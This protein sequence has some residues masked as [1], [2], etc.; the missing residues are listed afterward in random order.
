MVPAGAGTNVSPWNDKQWTVDNK[1][2]K[3]LRTFDG[4]IQYY[5]KWRLR[6]RYHFIAT[7]MYYQNIFDLIEGSNVPITFNMLNQTSIPLLP[8]VNWLWVANHLW[9]F[10]GKCVDDTML[11]RMSTLAGGEGFNG[12]ELW[13]TLF[14]EYR[15]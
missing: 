15:G 13:R 8:N 4:L 9:G 1:P 11:G 5:D 14:V 6:I 12:M 2:P 10:I 3:E 7:N